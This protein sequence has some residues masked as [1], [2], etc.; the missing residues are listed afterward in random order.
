MSRRSKRLKS[1]NAAH[2]PNRRPDPAAATPKPAVAAQP[3]EMSLDSSA[4]S[5]GATCC[6]PTHPSDCS[7]ADSG[8]RTPRLPD[9]S[10][11]DSGPRTPRLSD[12]SAAVALRFLDML[13]VLALRLAADIANFVVG[14]PVP[15][16]EGKVRK[17][18]KPPV[19]GC[20]LL[21]KSLNQLN[22]IANDNIRM[23]VKAEAPEALIAEQRMRAGNLLYNLGG[24]L[25]SILEAETGLMARNAAPLEPATTDK[26]IKTLATLSRIVSNAEKMREKAAKVRNAECGVRN[27]Q[28]GV[29]GPESGVAAVRA[30]GEASAS[31][32]ARVQ[33]GEGGPAVGAQH[34]APGE[35]AQGQAVAE[36]PETVD[37][38]DAV[39]D[40]NFVDDD[41][42]E[43]D[44]WTLMLLNE[45]PDR[46]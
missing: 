15:P 14:A 2:G 6:A 32:L 30:T 39:D 19:P 46:P 26:F 3:M 27:E 17:A 4:G 7:P 9:C 42:E 40:V 21:V 45:K 22:K 29:G 44:E 1:L 31:E 24:M 13:A 20:S 41:E 28:S 35:P 36:G 11:A 10:P 34:V 8:P 16:P 12:C 33:A 5:K 43:L 38:V 37:E 23:L 25:L 18:R